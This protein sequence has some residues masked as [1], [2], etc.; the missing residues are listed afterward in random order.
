[1]FWLALMPWLTTL[2]FGATGVVELSTPWAI[3]I[4]YAFVLLW[5]RNL[6]AEAPAATQAALAALRRAWWPSL[7]VVL[8]IGVAAG[9]GNARKSSSDYYRPAADAAQAIVLSWNQRHPE[10]PLQWVGGDWAENAM[11]SFYAQPHLRTIP[12]L[13]DSEY[14]RVLALPD[15]RRQPGLLLC[16]RGPVAGEPGPTAKSRDCE[17]QAQAWLAKLGL[18][19]E[20]RVLTLQRSGWRFPVP[21]PYAYA[22]FDVLPRAGSQP[23]DNAGL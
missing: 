21:T 5:L 1:M 4:G 9:W 15:W 10:Q 18:P 2:G 20:P 16:P 11:L 7:A 12:G 3:P 13:P 14:A 17:R 23:A 8:V 6:D 22:V 19:Q